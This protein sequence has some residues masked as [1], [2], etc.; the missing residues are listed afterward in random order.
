MPD[1]EKGRPDWLPDSRAGKVPSA[2]RPTMRSRS[3]PDRGNAYPYAPTPDGSERFDPQGSQR[4]S[5]VRRFLSKLMLILG[6]LALVGL[7][8]VIVWLLLKP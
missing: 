1:Y 5:F 6:I 3:T 4:A 8:A 2:P 7:C